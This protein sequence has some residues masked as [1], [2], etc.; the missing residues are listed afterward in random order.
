MKYSIETKWAIV[1]FV[2]TLLWKLFEKVM[3]WHE[4]RIAQHANYAII[5]DGLFVLVYYL[6][7]IDKRKKY[8]LNGFNFKKGFKF[9]M[10]LTCIVTALSPL[11]QIITHKL[12]SPN[13]FS[14]IIQLV[15]DNNLMT[16]SDAQAKFN[17][18]NYLLEN[19]IGTFVFGTI[20]S[21][22]LVFIL[23]RKNK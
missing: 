14:N 19:I 6:A 13:Y 9:G 7:I 2:V 15:T 20:C 5:Y 12:I 18:N 10:T 3:G 11:V 22:I 23:T 1:F 17:L 16:L 4:Q 21:L 8:G